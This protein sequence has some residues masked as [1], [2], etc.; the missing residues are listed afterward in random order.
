MLGK[1]QR[2][3]PR[4]VWKHEAHDFTP[5]L[6]QHV[7]ELGSVLGLDLEVIEREAGVGDFSA[8]IVAKDL[9]RDRLVIIENQLEAT[10]HSH[11]GQMITYAAGREAGVVVWVARDFREEHRQAVDWLNRGANGGTEYFGVV[12]ELLRINDSPPAVNFKLVAAPNEWRRT[13]ARATQRDGVSE[14]GQAYQQFFQRL[15]DELRD[16][17]HFTNARAGQPQNWYTF[18]SGVSG[19]TY[20]ASF[21]AKGRVRCEL[22]IDMKD[23]DANERALEWLKGGRDEIEKQFGEPLSWED[24]QEKRACRI[25]CYRQGSIED[26]D[27]N[28]EEC[29]RWAIDRLLRFKRVFGPKLQQASAA[30]ATS[31]PSNGA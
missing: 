21:A 27:E 19:F 18:T 30:A 20:S 26:S 28:I 9:G 22:Y 8:D 24:L 5:W 3:D 12:L 13:S 31:Q 6:A 10:D 4:S 16:K 29:R 7:E 23:A 14:K 11:L 2:V 17:H 25:A 1:L 15:I